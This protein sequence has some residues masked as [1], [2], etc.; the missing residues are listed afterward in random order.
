MVR[1]GIV[2][3][4]PIGHDEVVALARIAWERENAVV[5]IPVGVGFDWDTLEPEIR[6]VAAE[7]IRAVL[8]ELERWG[9]LTARRPLLGY[10]AGYPDIL[11]GQLLVQA[12]AERAFDT[13]ESARQCVD[14]LNRLGDGIDEWLL[15]ELRREV[16]P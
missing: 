9:H 4:D 10:V 12:D 5:E 16:Q 2:V 15:L 1:S 8:A 14:Q 11:G 7:G 3:S 6:A 13:R